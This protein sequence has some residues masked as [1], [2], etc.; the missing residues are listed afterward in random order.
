MSK[1]NKAKVAS[2]SRKSALRVEALEQRQLLATVTGSGTE[3]GSNIVHPNGNVY[4]QVLMT[5]SSVTVS[6]DDGQVTR[7]SFLD[8]NG[9]IVQAE[10]SGAGTMTVSLTNPNNAGGG[11]GAAAEA[12]NY[13]Q[14]GV[15]YVQGLASVT[16]Q[17]S[18]ANSN[19]SIFSVGSG[20]AVNTALFAD[21]KAGGDAIANVAT[22]RIVADPA[23]PGGFSTFGRIGAGNASFAADSGTVGI[24]AANVN[25]QGPVIIGDLDASN[26]GVPTLNFGGSSQFSSLTV[27]GGDLDQ[28]NNV[29][30]VN[31]A[32]GFTAINFT[33]GSTSK[34]AAGGTADLGAKTNASSGFSNAITNIAT[35][36]SA[37]AFDITGKSQAELDALF[38]DRT[39]TSAVTI[40]GDVGVANTIQ[41]A[42][43]RGG[44]TFKGDI[45][46]GVTVTNGLGNFTAE[47]SVQGAIS[48][49]TVGDVAITTNLTSQI[50]A[51]SIGNVTIGG[52]LT[53]SLSTDK[54]TNNGNFD[55]GEGAIGNVSVTGNVTGYVEGILG[56]GNITVG[57]NITSSGNAD[58]VFVTSS[59]TSGDAFL[60]N[61]GTLT[62]TGDVD[63][64]GTG[65]PVINVKVNGKFGNVDIK[66]GGTVSSG[67]AAQ[68]G[69]FIIDGT[70]LGTASDSSG[71]ITI[72]ETAASTDITWG[73]L[74]I[75]ATSG[76]AGAVT[77]TGSGGT[78]A[79]FT[80]DGVIAVT[81]INAGEIKVTNFDTI[82]NNSTINAKLAPITFTTIASTASNATSITINGQIGSATL[83]LGNI[84]LDA[85]TVNSTIDVKEDI[86][87]DD[88]KDVSFTATKTNLDAVAGK[89][90]VADNTVGNITFNGAVD[91]SADSVQLGTKAT[92]SFTTTGTTA[93]AGG[94]TFGSITGALTLK[95]ATFAAGS[96]ISA[97]GDIGS[98]VLNGTT[99]MTANT[100]TSILLD[101]STSASD[102]IGSITVNGRI[103]GSTT[104]AVIDIMASKI[105]DI[106]IS[107]A[108][109]QD[110]ALI[111]DL[112]ILAAPNGNATASLA[113]SVSQD[114]SNIQNYA[115]GNVTISS[116]LALAYT[117]TKLFSGDNSVVAL[118]KIGNISITGDTEG[119]QQSR[120]FNASTDAAW[121]AVGD[122]NGLVGNTTFALET[123]VVRYDA[124]SDGTVE[125]NSAAPDF[126]GGTVAIGNVTVNANQAVDSNLPNN[127]GVDSIG[128]ADADAGAGALE[129]FAVLAGVRVNADDGDLIALGT[130]GNSAV[131]AVDIDANLSGT[132]G[133]VLIS[134]NQAVGFLDEVTLATLV[135]TAGD[136][137]SGILAATSVGKV[138]SV[139]TASGMNATGE[140]V[141]IGD[142][143]ATVDDTVEDAAAANQ[144]IVLVV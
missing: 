55:T 4:D 1:R 97:V 127:S 56:I 106:T 76:T 72:A 42:E 46:G 25:V 65:V 143:N 85:S 112:S 54:A 128:G 24:A 74:K 105:G 142:T 94:Q 15:K 120:L 52:N 44:V 34:V 43:F 70:T 126:T 3:V 27:A 33:A 83:D 32:T 69:A 18:N 123:N 101:D 140:A 36:D 131:N 80:L 87:A 118:G 111:T 139:T 104:A 100:Q 119:A 109:T 68:I 16:I 48:A 115:I 102:D 144:I 19:V 57:G 12:A 53:G 29:A 21:G 124:A 51:N 50:L 6:A 133:D 64:G 40:T 28:T 10:F 23:N 49:K 75:D 2:K 41:A 22:L 13:N 8:L 130:A 47:K 61:V 132:V 96:Q 117:G 86:S 93:V 135:G 137:V 121:F 82:T 39:F 20:N 134:S 7:V 129:G 14:P 89:G 108:L 45:F 11:I 60:A 84:T 58:G 9:D 59:G 30:I 122:T 125:D 38:K 88:M 91:F 17:G 90:L 37:T 141:I 81:G 95:D 99:T 113:E 92:A 63:Q 67:G 5:G 31:N 78:S 77:I 107:S 98:I 73:G 138:Q 110:Q 35:L 136:Q 79:D 66:G 26:T 71:T 62:V 114:G 116:T 103:L